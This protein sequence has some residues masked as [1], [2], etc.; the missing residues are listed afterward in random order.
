VCSSKLRLFVILLVFCCERNSLRS[1][2]AMAKHGSEV[3]CDVRERLGS[4]W[5]FRE[6]VLDATLL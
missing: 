1:A 4:E 5:W 6:A 3:V 2:N